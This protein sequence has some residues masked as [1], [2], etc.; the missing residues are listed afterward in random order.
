M[1]ESL[2]T[3][4]LS[5]SLEDYLEAIL[6]LEQTKR[7]ART[8]ELAGMLGVNMSSV[9]GALKGL[10]KKGFVDHTPYSFVT[11]T[12]SGKK[13]AAEVKKRHEALSQFL[14]DV[15]GLSPKIADENA[16]RMEHAIGPK[17]MA[18]LVSFLRFIKE[19][20]LG[21]EGIVEGFEYYC[22]HGRVRKD[23]SKHIDRCCGIPKK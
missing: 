17:V 4:K 16:C 20:P 8:K 15:L 11:L 21:M 7:V 14:R 13:I 18:R 22:E 19:C 1:T 5:S 9:T 10:V 3:E 2:K 23:C 12:A 6:I